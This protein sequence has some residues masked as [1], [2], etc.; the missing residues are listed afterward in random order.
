ML[1]IC[2]LTGCSQQ[3]A[4]RETF[5]SHIDEVAIAALKR[6]EVQQDQET[7]KFLDIKGG[8]AYSRIL[9]PGQV[10]EDVR[11]VRSALKQLGYAVNPESYIFDGELRNAIFEFQREHELGVDGFIGKETIN[12]LNGRIVQKNV[13]VFSRTP[14][15]A[16]A[17]TQGYWL[18]INK[19]SNTMLLLKGKSVLTKFHVATGKKADETPEGR[20]K[21][22][23]KVTDP[24]WKEIPGGVPENP[25]GRRWIGLNIEG[26]WIYGIHGTNNPKSIGTYA[27]KGCIRMR[28]EDVEYIFQI[29]GQG[30]P[31]WIGTEEQ[32]KS[33]GVQ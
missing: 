9:F 2:I 1:F 31:I 8:I 26:G 7:F 21:I 28:N 17:P 32:L 10:G 33:W 5:D 3:I 6:I 13:Q 24:V 22:D 19:T 12:V 20:F 15:I 14:S 23:N 16:Q 29:L 27:S 4:P 18:I 30:S 25:L 11:Q